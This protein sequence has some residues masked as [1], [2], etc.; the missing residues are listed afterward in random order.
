MYQGS[1]SKLTSCVD[2]LDWFTEELLVGDESPSGTS[3]D[4]HGALGDINGDSPFS[5]PPLKVVE[6]TPGS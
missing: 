6:V 1:P 4:Y 2:P 3:E 5:Q